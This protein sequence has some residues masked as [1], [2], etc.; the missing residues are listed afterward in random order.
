MAAYPALVGVVAARQIAQEALLSQ[1]EMAGA[2]R[3]G[4]SRLKAILLVALRER[5]ATA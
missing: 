5:L 3:Y 4:L 1:A 2:A